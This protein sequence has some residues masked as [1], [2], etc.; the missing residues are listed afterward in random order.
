MSYQK[1]NE[2]V[3]T[4]LSNI[5]KEILTYRG[6]DCKWNI[7]EAGVK[8]FFSVKQFD[9][10]N[11]TFFGKLIIMSHNKLINNNWFTKD[12]ASTHVG[13][14][15]SDGSIFH[16]SNDINGVEIKTD[17][18]DIL[19]N[20][21]QYL[22][23]N[24]GHDEEEVKKIAKYILDEVK[25]NIKDGKAYDYKGILRLLPGPFGWFFRQFSFIMK[26]DKYKWFCSE[27]VA[28]VLNKI[29]FLD[30]EELTDEEY[31]YEISPTDLY[32]LIKG[33]SVIVKSYCTK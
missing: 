9:D 30:I 32:N 5:Q 26:K 8:I 15:F 13:F 23:L 33:K 24:I 27:L 6:R 28:S 14:I 2:L 10:P 20:P 11:Q 22:V 18:T 19:K 21:H 4:N 3:F 17:F 7:Q 1:Q 29:G 31:P 16:A 25:L 12:A